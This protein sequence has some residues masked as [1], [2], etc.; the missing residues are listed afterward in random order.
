[1]GAANPLWNSSRGFKRYD[2]HTRKYRIGIRGAGYP[3]FTRGEGRKMLRRYAQGH[4]VD[5]SKMGNEW[6]SDGPRVSIS[7]KS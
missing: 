6:N 5:P 1:M 3:R 7:L 2:P 4:K